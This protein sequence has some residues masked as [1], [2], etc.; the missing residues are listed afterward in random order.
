MWAERLAFDEV[1]GGGISLEGAVEESYAA[2]GLDP[3]DD[4]P[5]SMLPQGVFPATI[6]KRA[7]R[8]LDV[9]LAKE[10]QEK[11]FPC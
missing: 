7:W 6:L 10:C 8:E 11:N 5:P 9:D 3:A 1:T 2:F 4:D